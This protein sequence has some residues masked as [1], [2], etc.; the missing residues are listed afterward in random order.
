MSIYHLS[1]VN[2]TYKSMAKVCF[3][4]WHMSSTLQMSCLF[5]DM[6]NTVVQCEDTALTYSSFGNFVCVCSMIRGRKMFRGAAVAVCM[7]IYLW[8]LYFLKENE[9]IMHC[10]LLFCRFRERPWVK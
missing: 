1:K 7:S 5:S 9:C 8:G 10:C 6:L 2:V 4:D 3:G